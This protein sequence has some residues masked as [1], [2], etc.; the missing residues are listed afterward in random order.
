VEPKLLTISI[1]GYNVEGSIASTLDSCLCKQRDLLDII[2]VD[3]GATDNTDQIVEAYA[4]KYPGVI[5]LAKKENG[6]YGTTIMTSIGLAKGKYFKVLDGDDSFVTD[7]LDEC[8]NKLKSLDEDVDLYVSPYLRTSPV[9]QKVMDQVD[10]DCS[11]LMDIEDLKAP[12]RIGMHAVLYKTSMLREVGVRLPSHCLYTDVLYATTGMRGVHRVFVSHMPLY[13]YKVDQNEGQ[14]TS[15]TSLIRHRK[16]KLI[17]IRELLKLYDNP[18]Q[19]E[20]AKALN[21]NL[22][23]IATFCAWLLGLLF[24][25]DVS[26]ENWADIHE[27]Q[28]ALKKRPEIRTQ[29]DARSGS[30][31][32]LSRVPKWLYR[33]VTKLYTRAMRGKTFY[34]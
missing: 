17:V 27:I 26:E 30:A 6:G 11:G 32:L 28:T 1:A 12:W 29:M 10:S 9:S 22:A 33:P 8:L 23:W 19:G 15:A 24:R 34:G 16:D 25:I 4:Q 31:K 5:R 18:A 20:S 7:A 14:S 13:D 2:V 3:D 21:V